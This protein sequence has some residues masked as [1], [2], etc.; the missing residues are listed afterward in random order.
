MKFYDPGQRL[1]IVLIT[2]HMHFVMAAAQEPAGP[3]KA[4]QANGA[5]RSDQP[6]PATGR[7]Q[8]VEPYAGSL[9]AE[10]EGTGAEL[11][12]IDTALEESDVLIPLVDHDVFKV[13]PPEERLGKA[14]Y[15]TR[16]IWPDVA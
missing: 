9:P 4:D 15:D 13:I 3:T 2:V 8:V 14:V 10:F 7:V 5:S 6:A 12:D 11:V 16:G 1:L